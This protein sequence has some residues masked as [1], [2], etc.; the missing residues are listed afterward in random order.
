MPPTQR[1]EDEKIM[2]KTLSAVVVVAA[3]VAIAGCG[4]GGGDDHAG[5]T[6]DSGTAQK[7]PLAL[8]SIVTASELTAATL[9]PSGKEYTFRTTIM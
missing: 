8:G 2:L 9:Q 3:A 6:V 7:G 1:I 5:Y 4:G